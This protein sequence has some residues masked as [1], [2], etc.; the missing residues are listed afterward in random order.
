[1]MSTEFYWH[2]NNSDCVPLITPHDCDSYPPV[3][4]PQISIAP[5]SPEQSQV[6]GTH[7]P[8]A[9]HVGHLPFTDSHGDLFGITLPHITVAGALDALMIAGT[10]AVFGLVSVSAICL[11]ANLMAWSPA[12]LRN[13]AI[14]AAVAMPGSA[15]VCNEFD[16]SAPLTQFSA[17]A[18][19]LVSGNP[20]HGLAAMTVLLIPAAWL[21]AMYAFTTRRVQLATNGLASPAATERALWLRT[22]REQRAAARLS[23]YK[24][25]FS[26]GGLNPHPVLGRLAV[27][28]TQ[29]PTKSRT[30]ALVSRNETRLIVPWIKMNEHGTSVASSG[31]GKSTLMNRML[32]SW[33]VT[34]WQRHRQW[35]RANRPGRPLVLVIDCNGGPDSR[36]AAGKL[37]PWFGSLGVPAERIGIVGG[38][39]S[40][41]RHVQLAMWS[42]PSRDD[43]RSIL[44]MM[45]SGGS[46][47]TTDTEK[48]FHEIR[49]TLLHLI[50]DA[51]A[52]VVNGKPVG[53]NPPRD[54]LEFLS[55]FDPVKLSRLWGGEWDDKVP[56]AG[57]PGVQHEI[58][59]TK[60]GK[61]PVLDS[62]RAE[63]GNL[64]RA[65]GDSFDGDRQFTDFDVLYVILEGIKAPD[66]A[67][68]Q[69]A[70]L[71]C[72]LEQLAD[73]EHGRQAILAVDE[74][75]AVSD[76]KT[77]AKAWVERL[78]KAGISTWWFAQSWNGLGHDDDAREA[79][80]TA[81]SGGSILGGQEKGDKLAEIYGTRRGFDLSRKL[82]GG[83]A[84]GDEGNVQAGDELLVH[85]NRLRS[86]GKGDVVHVSGGVAR[87]GRVSPLD[88][89]QRASL[90][91]LPGLSEM[92][93]AAD[94]TESSE[95]VAPVIDLRKRDRA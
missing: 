54:W 88:E 77:R 81:A 9:P 1:M 2:Q 52:K 19:E 29:A 14:G 95:P 4:T 58:A 34:G 94:E 38:D 26:T 78:R 61:Q 7:A 5:V 24:L 67:R 73:R 41:P 85:P 92:R 50:V 23:R 79:L 57:V 48:Y 13:W 45:I 6:P 16:W 55:R 40:D 8:Q 43:L 20:V 17:G 87:F 60:A 83:S 11:V 25:P 56:W 12:R 63:F 75:S 22:Q 82:I 35:W 27:E 49:E 86:M 30:R 39:E 76:G 44:S 68:A 70:A 84:A 62:A 33:F 36:K 37:L 42:T 65:L 72:M 64:Y 53:E 89:R 93:P 51:P 90:R 66:R 32:V 59:S 21:A 80:V 10:C 91:P 69:F 71:G 28:S 3:R 74:F 18:A 15:I 46:V 47:P 31:K